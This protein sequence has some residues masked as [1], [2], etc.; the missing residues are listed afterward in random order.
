MIH[1]RNWIAEGICDFCLV[2]FGALSIVLSAAAFGTGL[3]IEGILLISFAH[4]TAVGTMVYA[5]AHV[6]GAHITPAITIPLMITKRIGIAD[7][8]GYIISQLVGGIIAAFFVVAALPELGKAV[9]YGT[10]AP[11]AL[12]N[13]DPISGLWLEMVFTFF[14]VTC[15]FLVAVHKKAP[16]GIA[17]ITMGGMVFLLNLIGVPLSGMAANPARNFGPAIVSGSWEAQWIYWV[18]PIVGGLIAGL[19]MNYLFVKPAEAAAKVAAEK[20]S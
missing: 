5:F 10:L 18:G 11:S 20:I 1:P 17:G 12:I 9:N 7:G 19:L 15:A 16:A 6:S 2:F 3:S 13:H 4:G 14:L 8:I